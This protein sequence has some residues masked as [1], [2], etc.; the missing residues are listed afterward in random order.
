GVRGRVARIVL[1]I[2]EN[3]HDHFAGIAMANH[4]VVTNHDSS[5]AKI[6]CAGRNWPGAF[7]RKADFDTADIISGDFVV[8]NSIYGVATGRNTNF[9]HHGSAASAG[10]AIGEGDRI[11]SGGIKDV[12]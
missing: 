1:Y 8:E 4:R 10:A 9:T 6:P 2:Q 11:G 3:R 7:I 12:V 5:I